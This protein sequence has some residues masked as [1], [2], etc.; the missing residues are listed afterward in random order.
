MRP[1]TNSTGR[2][3]TPDATPMQLGLYAGGVLQIRARDALNFAPVA[4]ALTLEQRVGAVVAVPREPLAPLTDEMVR[5]A[6]E[7]T[8]R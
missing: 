2:I 6:L 7:G 8:R 1:T 4:E 5:A 3:V